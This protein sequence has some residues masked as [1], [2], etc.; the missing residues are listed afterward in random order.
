MIALPHRPRVLVLTP[1]FP[2]AKGG[3][4]L[5]MHR[6]VEHF[7]R[8]EAKV[9]TLAG[10]GSAGIDA[11]L[12]TTPVRISTPPALGHKGSIVVLNVA[13]VLHAVAFRPHAILVGHVTLSPAAWAIAR[14]LGVPFVQYLHG[15]EI[16]ARAELT[17]FAVRHASAVVAV[18]RHSQM[19]A[20]H[21]GAERGRLH[22][23]SPG[24]DAPASQPNGRR[25][26]RPTIA[27][28]AR[29]DDRYKGHDVLIR[30][31]PLVRARVPQAELLVIGDGSLRRH[32]EQLAR[33][34]GVAAA[35]SFVGVVS[36]AERDR[37]LASAHVF[38]MPSRVDAGGGG[39]G[40][41]IA[42]LEAAMHGL[43][44]VAG[45]VAGARDAIE[46]GSTGLLVDPTDH[47]AVAEAIASL[48]GDPQR[49]RALGRAGAE[50]ARTLSWP[51][52]ARLVE[53]I[54]LAEVGAAA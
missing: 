43:P 36:D 50:R 28:A 32:Y 41:G 8:V 37:L 12:V 4:Q 52:A 34:L 9:V 10:A 2:P 44:A 53:D 42:Y 3:I 47:V 51:R 33:A 18:S 11:A 6:L 5:L 19:L 45:N 16:A 1:D 24:V 31:L 22:L 20:L 23:V 15:K 49:A 7:T 40:F 48:L 35:V 30:A 54:I 13:S 29:L 17:R 26:P 27:V 38:A 21:Y 39:E 25:S 46:D 14:T